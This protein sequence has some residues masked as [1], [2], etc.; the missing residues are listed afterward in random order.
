MFKIDEISSSIGAQQRIMLK[1]EQYFGSS[2]CLIENFKVWYVENS[3][4]LHY[5]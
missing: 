2:T 4:Q 5:K 1:K 3:N